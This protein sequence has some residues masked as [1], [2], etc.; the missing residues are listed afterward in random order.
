MPA[1]PQ[2]ALYYPHA[3]FASVAW[4]KDALLYWERVVRTVGT[5]APQDAAEIRELAEHG[6]IENL[7][8][9]SLRPQET[10]VFGKEWEEAPD[11]KHELLSLP[12]VPK[13]R[14]RGELADWR[15]EL[16][17]K[18]IALGYEGA[19]RLVRQLP[20]HAATAWA[21]LAGALIAST[22]NLVPLTDDPIFT[23]VAILAHNDVTPRQEASTQAGR[24]IAEL[25]VP[26]APTQTSAE[27]PISRLLEVREKLA[28]SRKRFRETVEARAAAIAELPSEDAVRRHMKD[29]AQEIE[30]DIQQQRNTHAAPDPGKWPLF[31]VALPVAAAA[32]AA[33]VSGLPVVGQVAGGGAVGLALTSFG[34]H[35]RDAK[36]AGR[37]RHYIFSLKKELGAHDAGIDASLR[38]LLSKHAA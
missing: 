7:C 23:A 36:H 24:I 31:R 4:V 11:P 2:A 21:A 13:V 12:P 10:P 30:E 33:L 35:L 18:L 3:E 26:R 22:C 37:D 8:G 29:F 9:P 5:E 14:G 38:Q 19:A 6:L 28:P 27:L 1:A 17:K 16:D 15:R 32:G 34:L 20:E 25:L